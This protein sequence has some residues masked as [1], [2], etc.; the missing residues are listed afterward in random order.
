MSEALRPNLG[1][2][3]DLIPTLTDKEWLKQ[4]GPSLKLNVTDTGI[5]EITGLLQFDMMY[6]AESNKYTISPNENSNQG[7][8]IRDNYEIRILFQRGN[9]SHLPKVYEVGSRLLSLAKEKKIPPIDLHVSADGSVCLCIV[10]REKEYFPEGFRLQT[11]IDDLVIPFFYAQTYYKERNEWP[12]GEYSHGI[13]G[14]FEWYGENKN[15]TEKTV[16]QTIDRLRSSAG[17]P[18]LQQL[19]RR[20]DNIK[21]NMDCFCQAKTKIRS[22]HP[23]AFSGLWKLKKDLY[24]FSI[25]I[26]K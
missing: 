10:E 11:F 2:M 3:F 9:V 6:D 23:V 17:W 19:L 21:G 1:V 20:K 14:I 7:V 16:N 8:R 25:L 22:C 5:F 12:W 18:S 24:T 4:E 26:N 13:L 15:A